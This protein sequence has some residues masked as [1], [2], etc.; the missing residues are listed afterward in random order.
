FSSDS[1]GAGAQPQTEAITNP[2]I[3]LSSE[4]GPSDTQPTIDRPASVGSGTRRAPAGTRPSWASQR[5]SPA[6]QVPERN[7]SLPQVAGSVLIEERGRGGMGAF[8]KA[9]PLAL[10]RFVALKRVL[11]GAHASAEQ[12]E[13]FHA[14]AT[15]VA[16]LDHENIVRVFDVGEHDGLPYFSLE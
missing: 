14:E 11:A 3:D 12:L 1:R 13:R 2:T 4:R 7:A 5:T 6:R 8:S 10:E 15:A 9:Y 16:K